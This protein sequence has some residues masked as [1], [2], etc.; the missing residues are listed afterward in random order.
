MHSCPY[1]HTRISSVTWRSPSPA[2]DHSTPGT[3]VS[4]SRRYLVLLV[5]IQI[6]PPRLATKYHVLALCRP[7]INFRSAKHSLGASSSPSPPY[8]HHGLV[9]PDALVISRP[10]LLWEGKCHIDGADHAPL[11]KSPYRRE[12]S[13]EEWRWRHFP[14]SRRSLPS[15]PRSLPSSLLHDLT[16]FLSGLNSIW[17]TPLSPFF[18]V[19]S[20]PDLANLLSPDRTITPLNIRDGSHKSEDVWDHRLGPTGVR[21][22]RSSSISLCS[23]TAYLSHLHMFGSSVFHLVPASPVYVCACA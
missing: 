11:N 17:T 1:V 12:P 22:F 4:F 6:F 7:A 8:T 18:Q 14:S 16:I 2:T 23:H 9:T 15:L 10:N 19:L 13:E 5:L 21:C 20:C 3:Q